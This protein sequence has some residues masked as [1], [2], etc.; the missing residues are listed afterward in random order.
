[1]AYN[2]TAAKSNVKGLN[3]LRTNAVRNMEQFPVH[4][5]RRGNYFVI[6]ILFIRTRV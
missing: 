3:R 1:M 2:N 5:M 6:H 4:S